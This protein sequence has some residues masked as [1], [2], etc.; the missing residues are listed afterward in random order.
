MRTTAMQIEFAD[1]VRRD[2]V[3][4]DEFAIVCAMLGVVLVMQAAFWI[5]PMYLTPDEI[6]RL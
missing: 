5:W 4:T 1:L 6:Q 3:H 2:G